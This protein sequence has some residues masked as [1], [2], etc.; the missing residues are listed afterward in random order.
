MTVKLFY[1]DKGQV[2]RV[3]CF[4]EEEFEQVE[5]PELGELE[6][7][8]TSGGLTTLARTLEGKVLTL[9]NKTLRYPGHYALF[10]GLRDLGMLGLEPLNLASGKAVPRDLLHRLLA[11]RISPHLGEQDLMVIHVRAAGLQDGSRREVQVD[12]LD[13]FD[14]ATGFAAME[15]TTGFH[16]AI[17]AQSLGQGNVPAGAIPPELAVTAAEMVRELEKRDIHV[18]VS[19]TDQGGPAP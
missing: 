2:V 15:R 8:T 11:D 17:V 9:K 13:R 14:A 16:M 7:F 1:L 12:V 4:A 5:V 10:K 3:P 18:R 19:E 6:A